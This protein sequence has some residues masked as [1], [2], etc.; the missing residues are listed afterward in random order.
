MFEEFCIFESCS[1]KLVEILV[2]NEDKTEEL[3]I[4]LDYY[5]V[6]GH[7]LIGANREEAE[8]S[9]IWFHFSSLENVIK[10]SI[11]TKKVRRS[12][13]VSKRGRFVAYF[14]DS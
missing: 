10:D 1:M 3:I 12:S 4:G 11:G 5:A 14:V 9:Q 7:F 13:E 2:N 8:L 6:I